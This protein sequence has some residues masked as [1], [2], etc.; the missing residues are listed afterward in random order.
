MSLP[1]A[2]QPS[3]SGPGAGGTWLQELLQTPPL[4][5]FVR[6]GLRP[7]TLDAEARSRIEQVLAVMSARG[8]VQEAMWYLEDCGWDVRTAVTKYHDDEAARIESHSFE[9]HDMTRKA[10]AVTPANY[11]QGKLE[12]QI[13]V[14]VGNQQ[15][16]S[17]LVFPRSNGF[18]PSDA[19][20]LRALNQWRGDMVRWYQ[21]P[22]G[23]AEK[24]FTD[25]TVFEERF[26]RNL[27]ADRDY[28]GRE[29][30]GFPQIL[31]EFN[32]IFQARYLPGSVLPCGPRKHGSIANLVHRK[33]KQD[34]NPSRLTHEANRLAAERIRQIRLEEQQ[35]YDRLMV[36]VTANVTANGTSTVTPYVTATVTSTANVTAGANLAANPAIAAPAASELALEETEQQDH[37]QPGQLDQASTDNLP[38]RQAGQSRPGDS[39]GEEMSEGQPSRKRQRRG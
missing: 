34:T 21:D 30:P 27:F 7:T 18:N 26:V 37:A 11:H 10:N 22:P 23:A 25:Y 20:H 16:V 38:P 31:K 3:A 39:D 28:A 29:G 19:N 1:T 36:H 4:Q 24:T 5:Q 13:T 9:Y 6:F 8:S 15:H 12:I 35:A 17:T 14:N 33:W 2:N 32:A